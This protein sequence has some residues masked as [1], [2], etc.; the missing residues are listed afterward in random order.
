VTTTSP[1]QDTYANWDTEELLALR[2]RGALTE[3][4]RLALDAELAKRDVGGPGE[5]G[6]AVPRPEADQP[7]PALLLQFDIAPAVS[8]LA[9]YLVDIFAPLIVVGLVVFPLYVYAPSSVSDTA[10][11]A[12]LAA[13]LVYFFI[14]DGLPRGSLG[15]HLLTIRVVDASSMEACSLPQS[16][17]RNVFALLGPLDLVFAIASDGRRLGDHVAR[18]LVLRRR[19]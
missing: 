4:A 16:I 12:G 11:A 19:V 2:A 6:S 10:S 8:R 1:F 15:K 13:W 17:V 18:T 14:K 5:V 9:A 7:D 3:V